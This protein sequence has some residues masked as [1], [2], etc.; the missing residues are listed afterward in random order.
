MKHI[1]FIGHTVTFPTVKQTIGMHGEQNGITVPSTLTKV[2]GR[3]LHK[4]PF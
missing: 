2:Y 3:K 4:Q 1:D